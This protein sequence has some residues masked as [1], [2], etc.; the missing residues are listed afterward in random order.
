MPTLDLPDSEQ[1]W[2]PPKRP[3][4]WSEPPP[5]ESDLKFDLPTDSQRAATERARISRE[6]TSAISRMIPHVGS[7]K[8]TALLQLIK[9]DLSKCHDVFRGKRSEA[10]F[11]SIVALVENALAGVNWKRMTKQNLER[12]KTALTVGESQ[13]RVTF[14][15]VKRVRNDMIAGGLLGGPAFDYGDAD[16]A[17]PDG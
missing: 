14:A 1:S 11:L 16:S 17:K 6:L 3:E 9:R 8:L 12:L 15:D 2:R 10:N 4:K 13:R 5:S 7:V